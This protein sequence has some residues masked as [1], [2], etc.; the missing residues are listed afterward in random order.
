[1]SRSCSLDWEGKWISHC[2][3]TL[4]QSSIDLFR[5]YIYRELATTAQAYPSLLIAEDLNFAHR[6]V[7]NSAQ[8]NESYIMHIERTP[9]NPL[10]EEFPR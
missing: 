1:M 4:G 10:I 7:Y 6:S 5:L 8:G 2:S 9:A 3:I